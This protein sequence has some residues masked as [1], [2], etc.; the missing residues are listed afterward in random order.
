MVPRSDQAANTGGRRRTMAMWSV[1]SARAAQYPPYSRQAGM[2]LG[3]RARGRLRLEFSQRSPVALVSA[4]TIA[5]RSAAGRLPCA[6][7]CRARSAERLPSPASWQACAER[8]ARSTSSAEPRA[9]VPIVPSRGVFNGQSGTIFSLHAFPSMLCRTCCCNGAV[10]RVEIITVERTACNG[11]VQTR[12]KPITVS[13]RPWTNA[14]ASCLCG[15]TRSMN[16][17]ENDSTAGNPRLGVN[18]GRGDTFNQ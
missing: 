4:S 17:T 6:G 13:A 7:P 14:A 5:Q 1:A 3:P 12:R 8:T 9:V 18:R 2:V 10:Q 15:V 16:T 11:A